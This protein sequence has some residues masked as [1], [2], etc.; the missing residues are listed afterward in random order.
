MNTSEIKLM[1]M[2][3]ISFIFLLFQM[4]DSLVFFSVCW[5]L[6]TENISEHFIQ[7]FLAPPVPKCAFVA[8]R[9]VAVVI[10]DVHSFVVNG[11]II[12]VVV[13]E[14]RSG[15]RVQSI[16]R[17]AEKRLLLKREKKINKRIQAYI[18]PRQTV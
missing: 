12:R 8:P 17:T 7:L 14:R 5:S 9:G 11:R 1:H 16:S 18:G 6:N 3:N 10:V 4:N 13:A 15:A 2:Y